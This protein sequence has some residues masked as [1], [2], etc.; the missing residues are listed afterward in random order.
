M[1][2]LALGEYLGGNGTAVGASANVI[3]VG[4]SENLGKFMLQCSG[5][6]ITRFLVS[7]FRG[8]L[9]FAQPSIVFL[10]HAK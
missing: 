1:Q 4:M 8:F 9:S 6:L 7:H 5:I 2:A 10:R 3:V